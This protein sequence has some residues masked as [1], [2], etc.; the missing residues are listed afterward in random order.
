MFSKILVA[1]DGSDASLHALE[2]AAKIALDNDAELTILTVAPYPPPMITEDAMPTYLPQYQDD[3]R[4]SY[5]KMLQKTNKQLKTKHPTLKTVPIVMEGK[6]AHTIL[7]AA[8]AR[9]PD[10]IVVGSRGTSGVL[11]W[12]LGSV[13]REVAD[14]CTVPVL[15][16]KDERYCVAR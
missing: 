1:V 9:Q 15:V 16:A 7:E 8:K 2:I 11:T 10:L 6:P 5:K 3:L 12:L 4:E 14:S 13:A